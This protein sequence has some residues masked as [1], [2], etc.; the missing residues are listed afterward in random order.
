MHAADSKQ[1]WIN[2]QHPA[3]PSMLMVLRPAVDNLR[4]HAPRM[5]PRV[6]ARILLCHY[7]D[8]SGGLQL[9]HYPVVSLNA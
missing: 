1:S 3:T 6:S 9:C 5:A 8:Y 7:F 4:W 2:T